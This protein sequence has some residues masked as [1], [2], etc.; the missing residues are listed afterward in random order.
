MT[1][2]FCVRVRAWDSLPHTKFIKNRRGGIPF[3]GKFIPK[4]TNFD[5]FGAYSTH[6][7]SHNGEVLHED[8]GLGVPPH[9]K[10][11][12]NRLR[13]FTPLGQI[14]TKNYQFWRF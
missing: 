3:F 1:V 7:K 10:F 4:I 14:Y 13:G 12:E 2:K 11:C 8:A 6:F 5:D 9:A